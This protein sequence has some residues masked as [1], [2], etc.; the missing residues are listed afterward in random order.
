MN[1]REISGARVQERRAAI[2]LLAE[3]RFVE[4]ADNRT[5]LA[6]VCELPADVWGPLWE[7]LC[8]R[9]E[10]RDALEDGADPGFDDDGHPEDPERVKE[11]VRGDIAALLDKLAADAPAQAEPVRRAA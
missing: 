9:V 8:E 7:D 2:E 6:A 4:E 5:L 11:D 10:W 1:I 3:D